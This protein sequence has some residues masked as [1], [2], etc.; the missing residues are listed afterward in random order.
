MP[1]P[2]GIFT[3]CMNHKCYNY[4]CYIHKPAWYREEMPN[5]Q[6]YC[7]Y[8]RDLEF[9]GCLNKEFRI[10]YEYEIKYDRQHPIADHL[11]IIKFELY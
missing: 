3:G 2:T 6:Y 7:Y 10:N 9:R 5:E 1:V 4:F 11:G 8:C